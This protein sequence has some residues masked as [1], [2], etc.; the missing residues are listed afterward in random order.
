MIFEAVEVLVPFPAGVALVRLLLL[1]AHGAWVW[2]E[3]LRVDDG[4]GTVRILVQLLRIVAVLR[5]SVNRQI[6]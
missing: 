4:K 6:T 2:L 5:A 3:R 1:H